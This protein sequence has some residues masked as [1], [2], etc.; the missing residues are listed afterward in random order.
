MPAGVQQLLQLETTGYGG[1]NTAIQFSQIPRTQSPKMKNAYMTKIGSIAK[2]PGSAPIT[3]SL[4]VSAEHL[5]VYYSGDEDEIIL[6]AGDTLFKLDGAVLQAVTMTDQLESADIYTVPFT[7]ANNNDILFITDGGNMKQYTNG[8]VKDIVPATDDPDPAPPNDMANINTFKPIYCWVYSGHV[9]VSNGKDIVWYSKRFHY[10]YFLG[11]QYERWVRENDYITGPGVSFNNVMLLPMRRGWG[12]LTGST[13]DDFNGNQYLNT[14]NGCIAPRSIQRITYPDGVQTIAYLSDDGVYE[15]YDTGYDDAGSRQ[16]STRS[17]M[18]DRVDFDALGLTEEEKS[19]A[20][21]EYWPKMNLYLLSFFREDVP[22]TYAYDTR[23][24][25][26]YPWEDIEVTCLVEKDGEMYFSNHDGALKK[27]DPDLYSDWTNIAQTEGE[28]VH[29]QRYSPL[30]S[31]EF[32]GYES[33]W[34]YYLL[35]SRRY[36]RPSN[37]DL[38]VVFTNAHATDSITDA[39]NSSIFVWD[40]SKWDEAV[41]VNNLYTDI[42]NMPNE[43]SFHR[44]AKYIQVMWENNRDEPVEIYKEVWKGRAS[45]R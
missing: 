33:Y 31:F 26:W 8:E 40:E 41:W 20:T 35:E 16:Y 6:S 30:L 27:F 10:D 45:G 43:I 39:W 24:G 2:R 4:G 34:D 44:K 38:Y 42:V 29:F 5:T 28:P 23:N 17:L 18:T 25:E 7:D 19:K 21:S 14:R 13:L 1:I 12:I 37:I 36:L 32:S 3:S 22:Y 9:F 15:I 11:V